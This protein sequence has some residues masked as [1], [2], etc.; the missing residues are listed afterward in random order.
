MK[1]P[2]LREAMGPARLQKKLCRVN[3]TL[4]WMQGMKPQVAL[5][6]DLCSPDGM[7]VALGKD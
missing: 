2:K 3:S 7:Q 1:L 6:A 4:S 5:R